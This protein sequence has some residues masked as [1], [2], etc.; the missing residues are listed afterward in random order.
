MDPEIW[1]PVA[2]RCLHAAA[3]HA[4]DDVAFYAFVKT[5]CITLPCPQCRNEMC[6]HL[7]EWPVATLGGIRWAWYAH[8]CVNSRLKKKNLTYDKML[9]RHFF[10]APN[11][12]GED[13]LL[14]IF[15]CT[16][17][18]GHSR[19][20]ASLLGACINFSFVDGDLYTIAMQWHEM[21]LSSNSHSPWK[22]HDIDDIVSELK[23][24]CNTSHSTT[25]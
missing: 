16:Y 5:Y 18:E 2:W 25:W 11:I 3:H 10:A 21:R 20:L 4:K 1:G 14:Y 17:N 12:S 9:S 6:K 19:D 13:A 22:Y 15:L 23:V 8:S 24:K 7:A